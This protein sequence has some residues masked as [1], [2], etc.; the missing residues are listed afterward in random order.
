M[1]R[2]R[3]QGNRAIR[4]SFHIAKR[5]NAQGFVESIDNEWLIKLSH[6]NKLLEDREDL[7]KSFVV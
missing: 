5:D 4:N 2:K 6:R 3:V 1:R 7:N